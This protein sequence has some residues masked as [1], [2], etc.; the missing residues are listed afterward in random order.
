MADR[1]GNAVYAYEDAKLELK[2][3]QIINAG[4]TGIVLTKNLINYS[5]VEGGSGSADYATA[6]M[7]AA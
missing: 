2:N 6:A 5:K 1:Q 7:K 4:A 3:I